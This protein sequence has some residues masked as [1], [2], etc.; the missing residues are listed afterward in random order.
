MSKTFRKDS[1]NCPFLHL[2][3]LTLGLNTI[4]LKDTQNYKAFDT[5]QG[6]YWQTQMVKRGSIE[7]WAFVR[8]TQK[9][10]KAY[11]EWI[12]GILV[13]MVPM[14]GPNSRTR[15]VEVK[16]LAHVWKFVI[17]YIYTLNHV[18][19][20]VWWAVVTIWREISDWCWK[21]VKTVRFVSG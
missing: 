12:T 13:N 3:H 18:L 10:Q 5:V 11:L 20:N 16:G 4:L 14:N 6:L 15:D 17:E 7:V 19:V 21:R 8:V 2:R 1:H 9:I